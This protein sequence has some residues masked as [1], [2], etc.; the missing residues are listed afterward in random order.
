[1]SGTIII[2]FSSVSEENRAHQNLTLDLIA[3]SSVL[4][5]HHTTK[6][7]ACDQDVV[8]S[9]ACLL[10]LF[11]CVFHV[12]VNQDWLGG[13][14]DEFWKTNPDLLVLCHTL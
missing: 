3:R 12:V 6:G 14:K 9:E 2:N 8:A 1:M 10:D 7:V 5:S 4:L 11:D 13:I